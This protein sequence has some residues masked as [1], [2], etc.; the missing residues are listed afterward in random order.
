MAGETTIDLGVPIHAGDTITLNKR[1]VEL[2]EKTGRSGTLVF[3][4]TE[5]V[6]TNQDGEQVMREHFTR[7]YR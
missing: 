2:Y 7:I 1:I 6:F 4:K 3:V 5:F